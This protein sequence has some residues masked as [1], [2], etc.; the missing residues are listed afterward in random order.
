MQA[1]VLTSVVLNCSKLLL[2]WSCFMFNSTATQVYQQLYLH[3]VCISSA[4]AVGDF[5]WNTPDAVNNLLHLGPPAGLQ[6]H[7][8]CSRQH[9]Q[10]AAPLLSGP[11]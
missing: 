10:H 6:Q 2:Q 3:L 9:K 7:A 8:N 11:L 1:K 4:A 5:C